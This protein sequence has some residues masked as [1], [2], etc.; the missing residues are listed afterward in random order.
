M[1]LEI[2]KPRLR[3]FPFY[4]SSLDAHGVRLDG[5]IKEEQMLHI[6]DITLCWTELKLS[7]YSVEGDLTKVLL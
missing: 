5:I 7:G 4:L 3:T 2:L 1:W 6:T